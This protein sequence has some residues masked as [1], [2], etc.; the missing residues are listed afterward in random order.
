MCPAAFHR[1]NTGLHVGE[2]RQDSAWCGDA[3]THGSCSKSSPDPSRSAV[4]FTDCSQ[5]FARRSATEGFQRPQSAIVMKSRPRFYGVG[6]DR[7]PVAFASGACCRKA[8]KVQILSSAPNAKALRNKRLFPTPQLGCGGGRLSQGESAR[9]GRK[10]ARGL[11]VLSLP[12]R[13]AGDLVKSTGIPV[14]AQ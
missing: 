2:S 4:S 13:V 7:H 14:N 1:R 12:V 6:L 5:E 3:G 11:G 8:V 10:W 9:S